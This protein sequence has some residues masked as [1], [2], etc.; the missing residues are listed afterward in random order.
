MEEEGLFRVPG[1]NNVI[2]QCK[3]DLNEGKPID[4]EKVGRNVHNMASLL[5][6]YFRELPVPLLTFDYY[7][8]FIAAEGIKEPETRLT[9]IKKVLDFIP[10]ANMKLLKSL[11]HFLNNV[12][13]HQQINKM[14]STNLAIVFAPNLLR[15]SGDNGLQLMTEDSK[16]SLGLMKTLVEEYKFI[17]E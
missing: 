14:H 11:C 3:K 5:K 12:M 2:Q 9:R 1:D 17:F 6:L 10:E 15:P 13:Q 4:F 8:M 7:D 16:Y